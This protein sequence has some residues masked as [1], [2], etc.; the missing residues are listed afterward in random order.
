MAVSIGVSTVLNHA[1]GVD[2]VVVGG[3]APSGLYTDVVW[4][5]D[6]EV[7]NNSNLAGQTHFGVV[8]NTQGTGDPVYARRGEQLWQDAHGV[9]I[10]KLGAVLEETWY[11]DTSNIANAYTRV[12]RTN[13]TKSRYY[14]FRLS[15]MGNNAVRHITIEQRNPGEPWR[16][17]LSQP[18]SNSVQFFRTARSCAFLF[19]EPAAAGAVA[20]TC[21]SMTNGS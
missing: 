18:L 13:H 10:D 14:R 16:V 15:S 21:T 4:E 2:F 1:S 17:L 8:I 3:P 5:V 19:G 7:F 9:I 6:A 20:V 11:K 12:L